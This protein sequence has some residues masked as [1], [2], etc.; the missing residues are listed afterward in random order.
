MIEIDCGPGG[1]QQAKTD[2]RDSHT[3]IA[4]PHIC[5]AIVKIAMKR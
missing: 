4:K 3:H 5:H 1:E 2:D